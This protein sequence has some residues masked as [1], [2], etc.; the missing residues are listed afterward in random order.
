APFIALNIVLA[1][2]TYAVFSSPARR[3]ALLARLSVLDWKGR[4]PLDRK[5]WFDDLYEVIVV[6]PLK[7][8]AWTFRLLVENIV[9]GILYLLAALGRGLT[10]LVNRAQTGR[11]QHYAVTILFFM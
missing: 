2:M 8:L 1:A 9:I 6:R 7:I 5:F 3:D 4:G 10:G 11:P